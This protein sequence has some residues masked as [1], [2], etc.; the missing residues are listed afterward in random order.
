V[1]PS[2]N[3]DAGRNE[4]RG[5]QASKINNDATRG[6]AE[7]TGAMRPDDAPPNRLRK[8][9]RLAGMGGLAGML[10]PFFSILLSGGANERH[11]ASRNP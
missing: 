5:P 7:K 10:T 4:A 3:P 1:R 11:V 9:A 8:N 6:P 2:I